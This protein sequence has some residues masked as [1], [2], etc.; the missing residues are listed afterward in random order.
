M[1]ILY[2]F[3]AF[4]FG[5]L[6]A[7]FSQLVAYRLARGES[8]GGKSRCPSCGRDLGLIDILPL[9]GYAVNRGRCR[10]CKAPIPILHPLVE[11]IGGLLFAASYLVF[12]WSIELLVSFLS[13]VVLLSLSLSDAETRMVYDRVWIAGLVPL[14][15]LRIADGT[16]WSHL[17]PRDCSSR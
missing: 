13:I 11:T 17:F 16:I 3:I 4:M 10:F 6:F 8:I 2:A 12:G 9:F 7:S 1:T 5:T 14:V 15:G